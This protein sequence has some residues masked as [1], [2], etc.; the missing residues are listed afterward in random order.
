MNDTVCQQKEGARGQE[1]RKT[2]HIGHV[3][4]ALMVDREDVLNT[5]KGFDTSGSC[6]KG[7]QPPTE[8]EVEESTTLWKGCQTPDIAV[9]RT[10]TWSVV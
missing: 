5:E 3:T 8:A 6:K 9:I 10:R 1:N 4:P 2:A 7:L